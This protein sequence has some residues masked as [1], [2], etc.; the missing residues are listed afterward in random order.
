MNARITGRTSNA[1]GAVVR[2]AVKYHGLF[3][4]IPRRAI[5]A[6][7]AV[8]LLGIFSPEL[9]N[10]DTWWHL[11][12]GRYLLQHR[13]LPVPDPFAY[14]TGSAH[15][16]YP[17]E[18]VVRR[19][20]LT[21][22]WLAQAILYSLYAAGGFG[23]VVL[24]RA[25]MLTAL[26]SL[27]GW[28]VWRRTAGFYRSIAAAMAA[29][30]IAVEF[31]ID[32]PFLFTYLFLAVTLAILESR[33]NYWLLPPLLL[34]WANCH[35]GFFLGWF[36]IAAYAIRERRLWIPGAAA[37]LAS[38][39]NP[40][41]FHVVQ[42]LLAYRGSTMQS[43]LLEW[44]PPDLWPPSAFS[45]LLAACAAVLLWA[46]TKVRVSDWLLFAAFTAMAVTAQR[47]TILIG[48]LA[49]ILIASYIPWKR[50][51][52]RFAP[53]VAAALLLAA[54]G[55]GLVRGRFFQLRAAEWRYPSG[56]VDFLRAHHVTS[57]VFNTYEFGGYLMWRLW[58]EQRVFID[59]RALSDALFSDYIRILYNQDSG[60]QPVLDRYGIDVIVLNGFEY[61]N[62][63]LYPLAPMLAGSQS[64]VWTLVF[65]DPQSM[66]F[67]RHPPPGVAPL[68]SSLVMTNLEQECGIHIDRDP[69]HPRCARSLA[70]EFSKFHDFTRARRWIGIYLDHWH[71]PD[72]EAEQ[73]YRAYLGVR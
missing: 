9:S 51:V 4:L 6:L 63:I 21:H 24:W 13:A 7:S 49:P 40:N 19:F 43:K 38:G 69:Q 70:K 44:A 57:R 34:V 47:N 18:S 5:L 8:L 54:L 3:M 32:R 58:P 48:F 45:V 53:Y 16:A 10:S 67:M 61:F 22:E 60:A 2:R 15:D 65:S 36:V 42:V 35:G 37:G 59:G 28:I 55:A 12:T 33:R 73:A 41:G 23:A 50:P 25:L 71:D 27:A 72:P 31:A 11:A 29:S 66:V 1:G 46:R 62:G 39:L 52:P 64:A 17:G 56:A 30:I 68:D 26:C 14:T 20:N